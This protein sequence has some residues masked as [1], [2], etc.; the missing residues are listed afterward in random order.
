MMMIDPRDV[1][2][3]R[4]AIETNDDEGVVVAIDTFNRTMGERSE[5]E[6]RHLRVLLGQV[7]EQTETHE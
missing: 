3:L 6:M 7:E 2:R 5:T 1:R 4:D